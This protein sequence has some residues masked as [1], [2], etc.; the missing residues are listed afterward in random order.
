MKLFLILGSVLNGSI[1]EYFYKEGR[2]KSVF[3][4]LTT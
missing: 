4:T 1:N 2:F 3:T